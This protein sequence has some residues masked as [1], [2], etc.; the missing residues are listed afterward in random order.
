MA[1]QIQC[2]VSGGITGFRE[3][4]LKENKMVYET[5]SYDEA[6]EKA[7]RIEK[8]MNSGYGSAS[9]SYTVV[10]VY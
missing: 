10:E 4:M 3:S 6:T 2:Q 1:Y 9:F 8:K 5:E 7:D